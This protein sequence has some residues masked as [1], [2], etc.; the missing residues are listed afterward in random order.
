MK[1]SLG[2]LAIITILCWGSLL[3]AQDYTFEYTKEGIAIYEDII[4]LKLEQAAYKI[5][6]R[7]VAEPYNLSYLHL[8]SYLDFFALFISEDQDYLHK[9]Q[10]RKS[11]IIR[12][13]KQLPDSNPYKKFAIAEVQLHSAINR[14]KFGK[15]VKS[16]REL[17]A[18]YKNL[19][20][21]E[22]AHPDFILNK[23][24]L[25]VIHSLAE[26]VSIPGILK[27]LFGIEGSLALGLQEIE[28]LISYSQNE[29]ESLFSEELDA[30]YLYI[31]LYQANDAQKALDYLSKSRLYPEKSLLATFMIA[32]IYQK[33]GMN[34]R[35]LTI[36]ENKPRGPE[37]SDFLYLDLMEGI[38]KLR[39]LDSSCIQHIQKYLDLFEG[40]HY[41]KEGYQKMAWAKLVFDEDVIAYKTYIGKTS[42]G[43][44]A[45]V[46]GDKQAVRESKTHRIPSP[47]LLTAR[48]LSDGGYHGKAYTFLVQKAYKFTGADGHTLEFNYRMGRICQ[49]LKNYP[50][51]IDYYAQTTI[52][53]SAEDSYFACNAALQLGIIYEDLSDFGKARENYENCLDMEPLDYKYSLHQKAKTGL[54]RLKY[55]QEK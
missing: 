54:S 24:S 6:A 12:E 30:I 8:Q 22:E 18:A 41:I 11:S 51:A 44:E 39:K 3:S 45:L 17:L 49:A 15:V 37:Y 27:K 19:K 10:E 28:T 46:D 35:A 29:E 55:N 48:L 52:K 32:K 16:A 5:E 23:K 50:D 2:R 43:E 42:G 13:L 53:G 38:C 31:L 47:E 21:N 34:D 4:A 20:A 40:R 14:S 7:R 25:S 1:F 9:S 36:L 33:L 26:T